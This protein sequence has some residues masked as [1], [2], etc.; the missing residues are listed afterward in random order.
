MNHY[1]CR[2]LN[3]LRQKKWLKTTRSTVL[4]NFRS[5]KQRDGMSRA[6]AMGMDNIAK[7]MKREDRKRKYGYMTR[8]SVR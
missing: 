7:P 3:D 4:D 6:I 2:G 1:A 8:V 5:S